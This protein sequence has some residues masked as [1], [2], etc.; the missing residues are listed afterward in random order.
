MLFEAWWILRGRLGLRRLELSEEVA[1]RGLTLKERYLNRCATDETARMLLDLA[2]LGML[3]VQLRMQLCTLLGDSDPRIGTRLGSSD[4]ASLA[5][6]HPSRCLF[7]LLGSHSTL[8][9]LSM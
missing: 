8:L 7:W 9:S 1:L 5:Q 4:I 6:W 3:F 2:I